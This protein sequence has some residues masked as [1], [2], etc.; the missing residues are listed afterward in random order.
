MTDNANPPYLLWLDL[1]TTGLDPQKDLILEVAWELTLFA[2]PWQPLTP[3]ARD[4]HFLKNDPDLVEIKLHPTVRDMHERSGL[5]EVL[6]ARGEAGVLQ[7]LQDVEGQLLQLA[8]C[9]PDKEPKVRLAGWSVHFDLGFLRV[10]MPELA[11]RLS[12]RVFDVSAVRE[13]CRAM[14][15]P[16][17]EKKE[18]AHRADKDLAVSLEQARA[19]RRWIEEEARATCQHG[20]PILRQCAVCVEEQRQAPRRST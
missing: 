7:S 2:A 17:G 3:W 10:R 6:R 16:H 4:H 15:M 19:C 14:G 9:W 18:A 5:L 1:E 13:F 20:T 11:A 12:Y 8:A